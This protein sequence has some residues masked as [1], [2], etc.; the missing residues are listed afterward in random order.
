VNARYIGSS[1]IDGSVPGTTDLYFD[2]YFTVNLRIFADLQQRTKLIE[3]VPLLKNTRIT[4]A[5]NNVFDTRQ[6]VTDSTGAVPLRY[7]PFLID[8]VGRFF[9]IELRK[10]F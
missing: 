6:R 10:L 7:Q 5:V 8:P 9:E 2:D 1:R 3:D 4:F